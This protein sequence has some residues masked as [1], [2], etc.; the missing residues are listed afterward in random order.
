MGFGSFDLEAA[1]QADTPVV[2][3]EECLCLLCNGRRW[4]IVVEA[5]DTTLGS[6]GLWFAV[7][8]YQDCGLCF[9]NPRPDLCSIGQFHSE[10]SPFPVHQ[11]NRPLSW[12]WRLLRRGARQKR[13]LSWHGQGRLLDFGCGGGD[14]LKRM[15]RDGWEVTG[16][17]ASAAVVQRLRTEL[18]L[19]AFVGSLPHPELTASSCDVVTMWHSLQ[20][21]HRPLEVLRAAHRLLA[22]GGKLI[23]EVPNIDSLPFRWFGQNWCGLNL[24]NGRLS[25]FGTSTISL[26]P[27]ASSR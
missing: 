26:P 27:G 17:D 22:P 12:W 20:H 23:V 24:R 13:K 3:W 16:V 1:L 19:R 5:P 14:F 8:Q 10:K 9:T 11:I 4:S 25:M 2:Q 7:V 18:G 15:Q 6:A 21:V